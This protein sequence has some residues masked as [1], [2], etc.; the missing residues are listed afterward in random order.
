[1]TRREREQAVIAAAREISALWLEAAEF[2][3]A[4]WDTLGPA[5]DALDAAFRVLDADEG[6]GDPPMGYGYRQLH[7]DPSQVYAL[8]WGQSGR[9][10]GYAQADRLN[11]A[12]GIPDPATLEYIDNSIAVRWASAQWWEVVSLTSGYVQGAGC[13]VCGVADRAPG[14]RTCADCARE[15]EDSG[16]PGFA[17]GVLVSYSVGPWRVADH[18]LGLGI[19]DALGRR[20]ASLRYYKSSVSAKVPIGENIGNARLI[21]AA[22]DLLR[23][24]VG[25]MS[26][27][28]PGE[29][30]SGVAVAMVA[31]RAAVGRAT[32][33]D[34]ELGLG[35]VER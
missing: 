17:V 13:D 11:A 15:D 18:G 26:A 2:E 8:R 19:R 5:L 21:A 20:V 30:G 24:L 31:A 33:G 16:Q 27:A 12:T 35:E 4:D 23:A 25:L 6:K 22:P 1:M 29:A 34:G 10:T 9:I 28:G 7:A 3:G 32:D 14:L